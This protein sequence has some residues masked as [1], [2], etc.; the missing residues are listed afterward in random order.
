MKQPRYRLPHYTFA[1][2]S[3]LPSLLSPSLCPYFSPVWSRPNLYLKCLETTY[4]VIWCYVN[5]KDLTMF[6]L[7]LS[8]P[9][10]LQPSL[11][12]DRQG[13]SALMWY[14][15]NEDKQKTWQSIHF[16]TDLGIQICFLT[17]FVWDKYWFAWHCTLGK[18]KCLVMLDHHAKMLAYSVV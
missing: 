1:L 8:I 11:H 9:W 18:F 7:S 5:K 12:T 14:K 17:Y 4:G 10:A 15:M 16:F 13:N 6:C 2:L 3:V